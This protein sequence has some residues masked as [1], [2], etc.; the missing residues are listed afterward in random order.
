MLCQL[1]IV[2]GRKQ[3]SSPRAGSVQRTAQ[4]I[5]ENIVLGQYREERLVKGALAHV[6]LYD[7]A[8][9]RKDHKAVQRSGREQQKITG[10]ERQNAVRQPYRTAAADTITHLEIVVTVRLMLVIPEMM[11]HVD[12]HVPE[13]LFRLADVELPETPSLSLLIRFL[14]KTLHVAESQ[15]VFHHFI[16]RL[17]IHGFLLV[18]DRLPQRGEFLLI[19]HFHPSRN[20][21]PFSDLKIKSAGKY[22]NISTRYA[23]N[24]PRDIWYNIDTERE[25]APRNES[26]G[27]QSLRKISYERYV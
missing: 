9:V 15:N 6:Y 3:Y 22:I 26:S 19:V 11:R 16:R 8:I 7:R 21:I 20:I 24:N 17:N 18:V 1:R 23:M 13:I 27:T 25:N 4:E 5:P 12:I 2:A 10:H 14:Q